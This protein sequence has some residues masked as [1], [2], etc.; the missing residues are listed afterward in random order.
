MSLERIQFAWSWS[1]FPR[2]RCSPAGT[3]LRTGPLAP[4]LCLQAGKRY[5]TLTPRCR[6]RHSASPPGLQRHYP[7]VP[8]SVSATKE[9]STVLWGTHLTTESDLGAVSYSWGQEAIRSAWLLKVTVNLPAIPH[10][11]GRNWSLL[12]K[13]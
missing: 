11:C 7:R 10:H 13:S 8:H 1:S 4:A 3:I 2:P 9:W 12:K 5:P 6:P